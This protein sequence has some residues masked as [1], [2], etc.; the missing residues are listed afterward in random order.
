[1]H[2]VWVEVKTGQ[3]ASRC[4]HKA[5]LYCVAVYHP[6]LFEYHDAPARFLVLLDCE[7]AVFE[8]E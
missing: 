8:A 4:A 3:V 6:E 1:L 2:V 5:A 7:V